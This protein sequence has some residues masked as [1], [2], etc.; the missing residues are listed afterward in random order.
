MLVCLML[1]AGVLAGGC[2]PEPLLY[3]V[4]VEPSEI[5]PNQDGEADVARIS[6]RIGAPSR[7]TMTLESDA[8][9][10]FV[11]RDD[12]PRAPGPHEA[13]FGGVVEG[14]MLPDGTYTL[15]LSAHAADGHGASADSG[16]PQTAD[17]V[18]ERTLVISGGDTDPPRLDGLAVRP[19]E[20]S[21]NQDGIGDRVAISYSL[22]EPAEVRL[23]LETADGEYVT[24]ILEEQVS[25]EFAGQPGPHVYDYDAG[26]DANAPP[27]P[28]GEYVIVAEARDGAGNITRETLPLSIHSGGQPRAA[29]IGDVEWSDTVL[30]L[31]ATLSFT[32]TVRNVG[33]TP[34]RTR[35]PEPGF[36]Y[37]ND[38]TYNRQA[39]E[40]WLVVASR[41]D[42]KA[43]AWV[44]Y[45]EVSS[46]LHLALR[47]ASDAAAA[48]ELP[49]VGG[50]YATEATGE[51]SETTDLAE[52][53]A[54]GQ[55]SES[56]ATGDR[57][58]LC[59]VV[60]S[61]GAPA[62]NAVVTVFE[63]D[64]DNGRKTVTGPDGSVCLDGLD[65]VPAYERT[66]SRS[67]GS[68]RLA[69]EYDDKRTDIAYPF[70]WQLGAT[71]DLDICE[72]G[73]VIYLCLPPGKTVDISGGVRFVEP[74]FRRTTTAY[75]ALM[76]EDV[77]RMHGP[78][79]PETITIEH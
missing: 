40:A 34:I 48:T 56:A 41:G 7:L 2:R 31:G 67:P 61:G 20:L 37:D 79:N 75:L 38:Q 73:D 47:E 9:D 63:S 76:H 36:V 51:D 46:E 60:T 55:P 50:V 45:D 42:E 59:G 23:W 68:V 35:G 12:L 22:D 11:L 30:P 39:P 52:G 25:G 3:D 29:L 19:N 15:R 74:P 69:L 27:P 78:Y 18:V 16:E 17:V 21:P 71:E 10:R 77:R 72:S 66:F 24:D 1:A 49:Q 4:T 28:D 5:T 53:H 57:A 70:R 44:G 6:Y 54:A 26:V 58:R 43:V 64:G 62:P 65:P 33:G 8:G 32:A 14:R 13:L